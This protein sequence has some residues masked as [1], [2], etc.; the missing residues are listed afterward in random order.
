ML[1]LKIITMTLNYGVIGT[2]LTIFFLKMRIRVV[3]QIYC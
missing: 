2:A 3:K 1:P